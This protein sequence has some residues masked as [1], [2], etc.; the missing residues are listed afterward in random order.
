MRGTGRTT[1]QIRSAPQG[2]IY[3]CVSGRGGY[4]HQN[5]LR[6][7]RADLEFRPLKFLDDRGWR[8]T[9]GHVIVDHAVALTDLEVH[10][11]DAG[12]R[13]SAA[14]HLSRDLSRSVPERSDDDQGRDI[15]RHRGLR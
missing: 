4:E 7:G 14:T 6:L 2:A 12:N 1:E 8:G 5:A 9:T 13:I 3:V 11:I 10:D 15:R